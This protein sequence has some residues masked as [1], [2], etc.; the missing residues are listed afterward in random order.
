MIEETDLLLLNRNGKDYSFGATKIQALVE[1]TDLLL[2]HRA[3]NDYKVS[4]KDFKDYL[5]IPSIPPWETHFDPI[6]HLKNATERITFNGGM[7]T[8][9]YD[10][11]GNFVRSQ[12]FIEPGEELV[13]LCGTDFNKLFFSEEGT[14]DFGELTDTSKVTDMSE[15][16]IGCKDFN[17]DTVS[18]FDTSNVVDMN[19][20]FN[21]CAKFNGDVTGWDVSKVTNLHKTFYG[22]EAFT[23][24]INDW[25]VSKVTDF[26]STFTDCYSFNQPL[27]KWQ[28]T[29]AITIKQ[30]FNM[31]NNFNQDIGAWDTSNITEMESAIY[32]AWQ[33]T[34]DLSQW[35][36]DPEPNNRTFAKGSGIEKQPDKQPQWGT[37][38]RGEN[39]P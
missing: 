24:N 26:S 2:I 25:D 10:M 34:Q 31:C 23:R 6:I 20:M 14:W 5:A 9:G 21:N 22:C 8:E 28:L 35:C 36:V 13:F 3:G 15:M 17:S 32:G 12:G 33:F 4:G 27:D 1:D 16:F 11:D 30:M 38:P 7:T 29:S 39:N 19:Y 37:C 18:L